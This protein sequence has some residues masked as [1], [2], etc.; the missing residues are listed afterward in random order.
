MF[1]ARAHDAG[2]PL[3]L[4]WGLFAI[5]LV[6]CFPLHPYWQSDD[7][8]AVAYASDA[9]RAFSDFSGNQYGLDGVVWFYR[10]LVTLSFWF[11]QLLGGGPNPALSHI[12]N[13]LAHATGAVLLGAIAARLLG[14]MRGWLAGLAWG[15][16]AASIPTPSS[17]SDSLACSRS[18]RCDARDAAAG[19][20]CWPSP[21][22]SARRN[23]RSSSRCCS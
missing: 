3:P 7:F 19:S 23:T 15:L 10:P 4:G 9:G 14:P 8:V 17:G 22:R 6:A 5:V 2:G 11:E 16:S 21:P 1:G 13:A 18:E 12:G 20:R